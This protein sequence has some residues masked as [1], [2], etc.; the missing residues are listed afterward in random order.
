MYKNPQVRRDHPVTFPLPTDCQYP[1]SSIL[2]TKC[3]RKPIQVT[4][5]GIIV[6]AFN[7]ELLHTV[8]NA[9]VKSSFIRT[10]FL[11]FLMCSDTAYINLGTPAWTPT[12]TC[13]GHMDSLNTPALSRINLEVQARRLHPPMPMGRTSGVP[14]GVG[15]GDLISA[16][17]FVAQAT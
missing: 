11:C 14:C 16:I 7:T 1:L 5:F 9:F 13:T 10:W 4:P 2:A 3:T 6:A 17:I 8:L 12:A 15:A